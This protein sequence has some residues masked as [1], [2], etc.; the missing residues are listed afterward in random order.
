MGLADA[1]L[2]EAGRGV[3]VAVDLQKAFLDVMWEKD[4]LILNARKLLA[5]AGILDIPVIA[6]TQNA[7]KLG[8]IDEA[9]TE[10][11]REVA[12]IDKMSFSCMG[13]SQFRAALEAASGRT[14]IILAGLETHV[15]V[16]QTAH[17]LLDDGYVVHL[18]A[19]AISSRSAFNYQTGL[20]RMRQIG[21]T[22]SCVESIVFEW[23]RK[24]GTPE[25]KEAAKWIK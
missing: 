14:Q 17:D 20:E 11:L 5:C 2:M 3:I 9:F 12:P 16:N 15:C 8:G 13:S 23:L 6:T 7:G 18:A 19:D 10:F 21:A 22:I 25:F 24:A 1:H 4:R